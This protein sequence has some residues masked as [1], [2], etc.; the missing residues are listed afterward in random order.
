M[1]SNNFDNPII[2]DSSASYLGFGRATSPV[3]SDESTDARIYY[4]D[5]DP[6]DIPIGDFADSPPPVGSCAI[7]GAV[8]PRFWMY[9]GT[10][11]IEKGNA[12]GLTAHNL[13][14]HSDVTITGPASPN[15][16][17]YNGA[18]W[19]N[20]NQ[21][22]PNVTYTPGAEANWPDPDPDDVGDALDELATRVGPDLQTPFIPFANAGTLVDSELRRDG[23]NVY[24]LIVSGQEA[25][26]LSPT[27]IKLGL[28][29]ALNSGT[30][31]TRGFSVF[32]G[33]AGGDDSI[34][35]GSGSDAS[36]N[37][38]VAI[39]LG[40]NASTPDVVAIGENA[41]ASGTTGCVAVGAAATATGTRAVA[42]G[43]AAQATADTACAF[44]F[45][46]QANAENAIA[47][48][49][50]AGANFARGIAIGAGSDID[51]D[52]CTVIGFDV[53]IDTSGMTETPV[54]VA[55]GHSLTLTGTDT[56]QRGIQAGV[57][58]PGIFL[59]DDVPVGRTYSRGGF[60]VLAV[61]NAII[62]SALDVADPV[63][64]AE[65]FGIRSAFTPASSADASGATGAI[66][67]DDNYIYVRTST[68]WKRSALAAF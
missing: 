43:P 31:G 46:A 67:W 40:T 3:Q 22:A 36:G 66:V 45:N 15:V 25:L 20:A 30:S 59:T 29:N 49:S 18:A 54:Y 35:I 57:N 50:G 55:L 68:G 24:N 9:D 52:D 41:D 23:A 44:G 65:Q 21:T 48:G 27:Q 63:N 60:G 58:R 14:F 4:V 56:N 5:Q 62:Q 16:L 2:L 61:G 28:N 37:S 13:N 10:Q 51:A 64:P 8:P 39:G 42:V 47:V 1:G 19:V 26:R 6:N 32:G 33:D 12:G 17:Q 7:E 34:A 53:D 38:S 11:W